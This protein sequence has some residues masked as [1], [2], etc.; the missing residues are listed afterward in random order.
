MQVARVWAQIVYSIYGMGH[1][2]SRCK[3][4]KS[5]GSGINNKTFT[6]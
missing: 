1:G 4:V 3:E 2:G 6:K 5:A